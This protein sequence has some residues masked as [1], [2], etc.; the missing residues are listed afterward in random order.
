[1]GA[2]DV[3][4]KVIAVEEIYTAEGYV[5]HYSGLRLN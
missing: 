3:T 1:M 2:G 4:A 5:L